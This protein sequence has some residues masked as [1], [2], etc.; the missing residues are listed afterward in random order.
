MNGSFVL[1]YGV[2]APRSGAKRS[3]VMGLSLAARAAERREALKRP[4]NRSASQ[5]MGLCR[6]AQ[7]RE[8][9]CVCV[10]VTR[11][12]TEEAVPAV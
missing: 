2:I 6:A 8:A 10:C 4:R 3:G 5:G 9:L 7:R 1:G 12:L 11:Q